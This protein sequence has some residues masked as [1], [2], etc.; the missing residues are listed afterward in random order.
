ML[1]FRFY[2]NKYAT[3]FFTMIF[4]YQ[5]KKKMSIHQQSTDRNNNVNSYLPAILKENKSGW[6]IEYYVTH[7]QT[8]ILTRKQIRLS[9]IVARYKKPSD[10]RK[11]IAS[12]II[13]INNQ[14]VD[15][16]NPF[17]ENEDVRMF[18][19]LSDSN[20]CS[21]L[22]CS[23]WITSSRLRSSA[24]FLRLFLTK[25]QV[26]HQIGSVKNATITKIKI[27]APIHS[28]ILNGS[29]YPL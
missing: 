24:F 8:K 1:Q 11:H 29:S 9:R 17:F 18:E 7:P 12:M 6:I 21:A 2:C 13:K 26:V 27:P 22:S 23:I 10:A 20:L 14:L 19:K 28:A 4:S 5:R 3:T 25:Y 15:G 16:W